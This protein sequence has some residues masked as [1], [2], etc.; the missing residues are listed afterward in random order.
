[1]DTKG[2]TAHNEYCSLKHFGRRPF[3]FLLIV[4]VI[5]LLEYS[6]RRLDGVATKSTCVP[7]FIMTNKVVRLPISTYLEL[8]LENPSIHP[9][10]RSPIP[11]LTCDWAE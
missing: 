6:T 10:A 1:M 2:T 4:Q 5:K 7:A 9:S 3:A 11:G 8:F